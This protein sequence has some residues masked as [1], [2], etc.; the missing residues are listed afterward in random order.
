MIVFTHNS[1]ILL[2]GRTCLIIYDKS[3]HILHAKYVNCF[4]QGNEYLLNNKSPEHNDGIKT[5]VYSQTFEHC[6]DVWGIDFSLSYTG[7]P[8]GCKVQ[9]NDREWVM[10]C[11]REWRL[12]ARTQHCNNSENHD[13]Q[14]TNQARELHGP[15]GI[16]QPVHPSCSFRPEIGFNARA[17]KPIATSLA[18]QLNANSD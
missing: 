8:D 3:I 12:R 2:T 6:T 9:S 13:S 14:I 11:W 10:K 5:W 18:M 16:L 15:Q 4:L 7:D 17:E 1:F